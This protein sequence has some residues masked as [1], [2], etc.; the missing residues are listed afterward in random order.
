MKK[1]GRCPKCGAAD[2]A[3]VPPGRYNSIPVGFGG[4]KLE[5]Y[6]CLSCGFTE[7]WVETA[8][9]EKVRR[10]YGEPSSG[11]TGETKS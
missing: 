4:A 8:A 10:Y 6:I 1:T 2:I 11:G 5:R 7:E 9:M 3:V